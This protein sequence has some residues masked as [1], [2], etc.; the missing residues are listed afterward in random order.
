MHTAGNAAGRAGQHGPGR[1]S[2]RLGDRRDAA[3]RLDDQGRT[4][5]AG[6]RQAPLEARQIARQGR[7]DIGID[8]G[9]RDP[10]VLLDLRQHV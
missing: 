3:M 7:A 10:F 5:V 2:A 9:R 6:L 4:V 8:D 1:Q